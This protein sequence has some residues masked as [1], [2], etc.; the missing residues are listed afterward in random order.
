MK[1]RCRRRPRERSASALPALLRRQQ[2]GTT[3]RLEGAGLSLDVARQGFLE[4]RA[5]VAESDLTGLA[6]TWRLDEALTVRAALGEPVAPAAADPLGLWQQR[7]G[8]GQT[9]SHVDLAAPASIEVEAPLDDDWRVS[10]TLA[11]DPGGGF[12]AMAGDQRDWAAEPGG[13]AEPK[14]GRLA[15]FGLARGAAAT[16]GWRIG[17]GLLDEADGPLGS[18]GSGALATGGAVTQFV[19]VA[20]SWPVTAGLEAFGRAALGRTETSGQSGL[21]ADVGPLWS[22]AFA[23]GL[24]IDSVA[25]ADDRLSFTVS[26]PLRVEAGMA[27]LDVPV[28][29]DVEGNV[30]RARRA[31]DLQPAA[32]R[33]ISRSATARPRQLR[34]RAG[35]PANGAHAAPRPGPRPVGAP[36][37]ALR[38]RLPIAV[39]TGTVREAGSRPRRDRG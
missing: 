15:A 36:G 26:Q 17:L 7:Q 29:R 24:A 10:L 1:W 22:T 28:A 19:D 33:S 32:A 39:L 2:V 37:A 11:G 14:R 23:L 27:V 6:A 25:R 9:A 31:L 13:Y 4:Q 8:P 38:P 3:E 18:S 30:A 21:L 16:G 35:A 12:A 5:I 20:A 34:R